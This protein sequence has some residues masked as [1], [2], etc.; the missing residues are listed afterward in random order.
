M[1]PPATA[2]P[3]RLPY[4]SSS[5]ETPPITFYC[6]I[7]LLLVALSMLIDRFWPTLFLDFFGTIPPP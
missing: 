1:P 3:T 4:E 2:V 6:G 5:G 7:E